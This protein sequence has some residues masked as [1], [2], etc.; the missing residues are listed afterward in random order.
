LRLLLSG[1]ESRSRPEPHVSE[2]GFD[3][4][5]VPV[6]FLRLG[7]ELS[8]PSQKPALLLVLRAVL[9]PEEGEEAELEAEFEVLEV[10]V[11][12]VSE[13]EAQEFAGFPSYPV[14]EGLDARRPEEFGEAFNEAQSGAEQGFNPPP[15]RVVLQGSLLEGV[16]LPY[17]ASQRFEELPVD[18]GV[19][20]ASG[21]E[22]VSRGMRLVKSVVV[23]WSFL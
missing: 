11:R 16:E 3:E 17:E 6:E 1:G 18:G 19:V 2:H 4:S 7:E 10:E 20:S 13:G 21:G 8:Q 23:T 9:R 14:E 15:G 5:A 12:G 22:P